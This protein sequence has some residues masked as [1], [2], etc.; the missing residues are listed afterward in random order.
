MYFAAHAYV[1]ESV[2]DP[3]K[4]FR[5]NVSAA[6]ALL[7][8]VLDSK[9]RRFIFSSTCAVY[10]I[11]EKVPI[12]EDTPRLPVNPYGN[13]KL[14]FEHALE[15]YGHAYGGFGIALSMVAFLGILALFWVWV[16]AV[17]GVY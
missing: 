14:A 17:M 5:N 1:G 16:A 10:G 12:N 15:A 9:V 2:T 4:Y 11:P 6:L 7:D 13:T 3:R 8:A